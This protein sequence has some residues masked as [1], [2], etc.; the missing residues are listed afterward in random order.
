MPRIIARALLA[1]LMVS[2]GAGCVS[3]MRKMSRLEDTLRSYETAIRWS[4]FDAAS[5]FQAADAAPQPTVDYDRL[6]DVKVTAY[7]VR[8]SGVSED[9]S[10]ATQTV[11]IEYYDVNTMRQFSVIDRQT[12]TYDEKRKRWLLKSGLPPF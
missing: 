7:E 9:K 2:V 4:D 6:A 1:V 12:W 8:E 3:S 5:R 11:G 10:E